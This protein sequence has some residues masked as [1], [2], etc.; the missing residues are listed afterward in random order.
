MSSGWLWPSSLRWLQRGQVDTGTEQRPSLTQ[1]L[2]LTPLGC[3]ILHRQWI[4]LSFTFPYLWAWDCHDD[5]IRHVK[6]AG[7]WLGLE[8]QVTA[9]RGWRDSAGGSR[10]TGQS[11]CAVES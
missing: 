6:C 5:Y 9:V 8:K 7:V 1:V 11:W 2:S 10:G 3:V 4:P